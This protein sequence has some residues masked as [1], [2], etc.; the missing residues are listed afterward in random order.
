M[1]GC[2]DYV[3]QN[4]YVRLE[5]EVL[6]YYGDVGLDVIYLVLIGWFYVFVGFF[7]VDGFFIDVDFVGIGNFQYVDV[8]EYG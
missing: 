2:F 7:Q 8:V 3:F 5:I 4:G 6:E 1:Y